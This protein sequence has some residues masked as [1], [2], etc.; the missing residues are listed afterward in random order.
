MRTANDNPYLPLPV[1]QAQMMY[2][3]RQSQQPRLPPRRNQNYDTLPFPRHMM[4]IPPQAQNHQY[5]NLLPLP[6]TY[7]P[8]GNPQL[9]G[10][11]YDNL[12]PN[13]QMPV[14]PP[15]SHAIYQGQQNYFR[16][17]APPTDDS[18]DDDLPMLPER[19]P[20][21]LVETEHLRGISKNAHGRGNGTES[22]MQTMVMWCYV[23]V[24]EINTL[25]V[26]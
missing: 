5:Y 4:Q 9:R 26:C 19:K 10:G 17:R 20:T 24:G 21:K 6:G 25:D 15:R 2:L 16:S 8:N 13:G 23:D 3:A 12:P 18:S 11:P 1:D 22:R 7:I 14:Y